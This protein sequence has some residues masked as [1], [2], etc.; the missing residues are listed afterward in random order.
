MG[1]DS[2]ELVLDIEEHFRI[3]L[4]DD[5]CAGIVTVADLAV[6]VLSQLPEK[7]RGCPTAAHFRRLRVQAEK[8]VGVSRR[9]FRPKTPLRELFP[10]SKRREMWAALRKGDVVIS[11]LVAPRLVDR[12]FLATLVVGLLSWIVGWAWVFLVY[13]EQAAFVGAVAVLVIGIGLLAALYRA[14]MVSLPAGYGTVGDLV[15][16]TMPPV[17]PS[18]AG[19]RLAAEHAVLEEVCDLTARSL[20]VKRERVRPESRL[21]EDLGMN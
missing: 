8:L 2:V 7:R 19:A 5:Q 12:A 3:R 17:M 16:L 10:R 4:P 1:L 14:C 11:P 13:G 9:E 21:V 6:A 15:R 20:S 18:G